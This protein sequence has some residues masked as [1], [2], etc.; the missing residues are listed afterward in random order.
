MLVT[1]IQ[2]LQEDA[3]AYHAMAVCLN[4]L[5]SDCSHSEITYSLV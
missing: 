1:C 4:C 5:L 2:I 3:N